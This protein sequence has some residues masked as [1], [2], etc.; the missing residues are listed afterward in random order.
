MTGTTLHNIN[1]YYPNRRKC[2]G[3]GGEIISDNVVCYSTGTITGRSFA[4]TKVV[5]GH[6]YHL[7]VCDKC[8]QEKYPGPINLGT[9]CEKSKW[10]FGIND[11]DYYAARKNYAMSKDKMVSK[12]GE[13]VG[14]KKWEAYCKRQA[15]TNTFEYKQKKYGW[16]KEQ[17]DEY[18]SDR[19]VTLENLVRRHGEEE[20]LKKWKK[21]CSRQ[22]LTKSRQYVVET[23]GEERW[24]EI[25]DAKR[26]NVENFIHRYGEVEGPIR[27]QQYV[28]KTVQSYS[29]VSQE[30]FRKLDEYLGSRYTTYFATKNYEYAVDD[31][32]VCH[33]DYFIEELNISIEFNGDAWHRNPRKYEGTVHCHP[34]N[35]TIT[36]AELQKKDELRYKY[37]N[38]THN[39]KTF[40]IWESEYKQSWSTR[41]FITNIL[42]IEL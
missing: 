30:C 20:G 8:I 41:D 25:C 3:C 28:E 6:I 32:P 5:N 40:V 24:N 18:N 34:M 22:S 16:N 12:Y 10:A 14:L 17:F 39:I 29:E 37:L 13:K 23:Y 38:E 21:Y 11:E 15:E 1:R 35:K 19:A 26:H 27:W 7:L 33:L 36:A 31:N 4:S 2:M 9:I 42:K